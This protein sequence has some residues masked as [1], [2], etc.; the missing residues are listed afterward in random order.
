VAQDAI[1]V[2]LDCGTDR[3]LTMEPIV[4][5]GQ[6]VA[7]LGQRILGRTAADDIVNP[8]ERRRHHC[9]GHAAHG[10]GHRRRRGSQGP[11]GAYPFAR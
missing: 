3:G 2:Q 5:S 4:D 10:K 6:V 1:I 7:T 9:Q 8:R 11:D